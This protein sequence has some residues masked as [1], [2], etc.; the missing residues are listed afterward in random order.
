MLI[1]F[2]RF[3]VKRPVLMPCSRLFCIEPIGIGTPWVESLTGYVARIADAH[4]LSVSLLFGYELAPHADKEYLRRAEL[5]AKYPC[6]IF[7]SAF[8]P[9]ARAMNGLGIGASEWTHILQNL[10]LRNDLQYLTM[11]P[12]KGIL[13]GEQLLRPMRAWCSA[14]YRDWYAEDKTIYEPLLWAIKTVILCPC[15]NLPLRTNCNNCGSHLHP[16][17]SRSKPGFCSMCEQW[18]GGAENMSQSGE[19]IL[20]IEEIEK[21][22]WQSKSVGELLAVTLDTKSVPSREKIIESLTLL[23]L[24]C[25]GKLSALA[26]LLKMNKTT[27]WQWK[28]GRNLPQFD[29][30]L[31]FCCNL[32]MSVLDFLSGQ[33]TTEW[34]DKNT[35]IP[36]AGGKLTIQAAR[37]KK[38]LNKT[39]TQR[40][41]L[42]TLEEIPPPSLKKVAS[43]LG[44]DGNTLRYQFPDLCKTIV[45]RYRNYKAT[46][47]RKENQ[48]IVN[49]LHGALNKEYDPP[50]LAEIARQLKYDITTLRDHA[51]T[52]CH[53][54]TTRHME[55][56][57]ER[58]K[59]IQK[60]IQAALSEYPLLP[61][62]NLQSVSNV[63]NQAFTHTSPI[64]VMRL[65]SVAQSI[66]KETE[67]MFAQPEVK[68]WV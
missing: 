1:S 25:K 23:V 59:R 56:R 7:A 41:L 8:R 43:Q 30:L 35:E 32:D 17:A 45:E 50:S 38:P 61:S 54:V 68:Y 55:C 6:R 13:S 60:S 62:S 51:S 16:L 28:R 27:V 21:L 52:L 37:K 9:Q 10:T 58:W 39:E 40:A 3:I 4:Q 20:K 29:L 18:L 48:R 44:R 49:A 26:Q 65:Q 5:R 53:A 66:C 64:H 42:S 31:N 34:L 24:K 11:L 46:S 36:P 33:I 2:Q 12:W 15:H 67:H 19:G 22:S 47:P 57:K 14:C 63:V